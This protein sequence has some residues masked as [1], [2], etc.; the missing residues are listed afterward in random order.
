MNGKTIGHTPSDY[1]AKDG[2]KDTITLESKVFHSAL[3]NVNIPLGPDAPGGGVVMNKGD[4]QGAQTVYVYAPQDAL[5]EGT[6]GFNIIHR[7]QQGKSAKDGDA[8][9]GRG[10][11]RLMP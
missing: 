1:W 11:P 4:H 5:A 8:Y 7:T 6:N 9:D 2:E 3:E 10:Q